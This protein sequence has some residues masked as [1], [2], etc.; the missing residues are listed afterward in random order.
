MCP[1]LLGLARSCSLCLSFPA[2]QCVQPPNPWCAVVKISPTSEPSLFRPD[3]REEPVV[4]DRLGTLPEDH[5]PAELIA[6]I[7]HIDDESVQL[8]K[9]VRV[10]SMTLQKRLLDITRVLA[11]IWLLT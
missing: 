3:W 2:Q 9:N 10:M 8:L 7:W 11:C 1:L 4:T 5:I 6:L